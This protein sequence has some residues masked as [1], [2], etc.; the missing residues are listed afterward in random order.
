MHRRRA[1]ASQPA[2]AAGTFSNSYVTT[3]APPASAERRPVVVGADEQ[4]GATCAPRARPAP[5][6]GSGSGCRAGTR[7]A[8]ACG[9]AGRRPRSP[10]LHH[11]SATPRGRGARARPSVCARA[12]RAR[13]RSRTVGVVRRDDRGGQQRR[14]DGAGRGRSRASPPARR[15][16]SARSRAASPCR[17]APS[18]RPARRAPAAGL[19]GRHAGQVRRAAGAGDDHLAGRAPRAVDA[20]SN[21]R[22]GVRC[23]ET[24]RVSCG[25]PSSS[26]VS[27]RVAHRLPVGRRAHD[28]AHQRGEAVAHGRGHYTEPRDG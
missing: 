20:Y 3:S 21:S 13:A 2:A 19:G 23:A 25:T 11:G 7:P 14:V 16:A 12:E 28:D 10:T 15:P 4:L 1:R 18:T 27:H 9:R 26:S 5:G 8:P 17:A 24:T 22:S 6:R